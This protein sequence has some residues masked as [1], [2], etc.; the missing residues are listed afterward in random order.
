MQDDEDIK[1][2]IRANGYTV[3]HPCG[4]ARMGAA[5]DVTSVV[6]PDLKVIGIEG[7]R[8]R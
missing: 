6:D 4:T 5:S 1:T 2:F 7:L 8:V 3:H